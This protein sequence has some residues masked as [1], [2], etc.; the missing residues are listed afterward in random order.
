MGLGQ[1]KV[2]LAQGLHDHLSCAYAR[3]PQA[4]HAIGRMAILGIPGPFR[5][6]GQPGASGTTALVLLAIAVRVAP[7]S[8]L[9]GALAAPGA[10]WQPLSY[11]RSDQSLHLCA[12][13]IGAAAPSPAA[14]G[15]DHAFLCPAGGGGGARA[16]A[17]RR[18]I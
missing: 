17:L 1:A 8:R 6:I 15:A 4:I 5:L 10:A 3:A 18:W 11:R 2:T 13:G 14:M 16:A 7:S 9:G 12:G